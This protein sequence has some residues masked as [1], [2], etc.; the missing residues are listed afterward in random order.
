MKGPLAVPKIGY[1]SLSIQCTPHKFVYLVLIPLDKHWTKWN[2]DKIISPA[3][4]VTAELLLSALT[5][6]MPA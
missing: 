5:S 3:L 6:T 2:F 1:S 4:H